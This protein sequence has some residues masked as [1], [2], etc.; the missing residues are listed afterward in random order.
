MSRAAPSRIAVLGA[1]PGGMA[2]AAALARTG[3]D[4]T[5][6]NR[7]PARLADVAAAG[8]VT[9]EGENGNADLL[10]PLRATTDAHEA[11]AA[12]DLLLCCV[13]ADGQPAL[14]DEVIPHLDGPTVVLL[15]PGS[16]GSL[17]LAQR[18]ADAGHDVLGDILVGELLT[19]P[20]SA[21]MTGPG[22][23]R[24]RLPS[25]N[26]V[27]AF[28]AVRAAELYEAIDPILSWRP[29]PHV[30][31]VGLNNV[32]FIIHPGPMLLNYAAIERADGLLSLMNEG[33]TPGVL[34]LMDAIDAEKMDLLE[35]L[36]LPRSDIDSIYVELGNSP[37]VYRSPGEPFNLRDRIWPRYIT[38]DT[39]C[40]TV[41]FSSL[42]RLLGVPTPMS[43]ATN[44][45]LSML[46]GR[47]FVAE[48]RTVEALGLGGMSR[49]DVLQYLDHGPV[50][51]TV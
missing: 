44:A 16:A 12:A 46:E 14:F 3:L 49:D 19:L 39:P 22:R 10:V 34:R 6:F 45:L 47:D 27:A 21:R 33:M 4:V 13:P 29:S 35:A 24:M 20:Q 26:R 18:L 11:V 38:E 23:V 30:L 28:P 42:G 5:L 41:M 25:E 48:G 9:V 50:P 15:A 43:D 7:T 2:S 40:G 8:G 1:G 31:D 32:N 17:I 37:A 51:S 36:G